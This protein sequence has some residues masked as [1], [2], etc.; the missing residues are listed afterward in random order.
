[1]RSG[2]RHAVELA[3]GVVLLAAATALFLKPARLLPAGVRIG[4]GGFIALVTTAVL[5][6]MLRNV[7]LG[8]QGVIGELAGWAIVTPLLVLLAGTRHLGAVFLFMAGSI[9]IDLAACAAHLVVGVDIV[10]HSAW[11]STWQIVATAIAAMQL[12]GQKGEQ[13]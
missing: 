9:G 2:S 1:M 10:E 6:G 11:F 8:P 7:A 3:G 12:G 4:S 13:T 5:A